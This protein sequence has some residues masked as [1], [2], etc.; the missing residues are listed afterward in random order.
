MSL[1]D[2][3]ADETSDLID[4]SSP[5]GRREAI[6]ATL[7]GFIDEGFSKNTILSIYRSENAGISTSDFNALYN[8]ALN[9]SVRERIS[10]FPEYLI[11]TDAFF[12]LGSRN[13][14]A[15]YSFK[16]EADVVDRE[17]GM[18]V[19]ITRIHDLDH[20]TNLEDIAQIASEKILQSSTYLVAAVME[21]RFIGAWYEY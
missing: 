4:L 12:E 15:N 20:L 5:L 6:N 2:F 9:M 18:T 13:V 11:P 10:V 8:Q 7:F 17:T 1:Y 14:G 19:T 3:L 21:I 16:L